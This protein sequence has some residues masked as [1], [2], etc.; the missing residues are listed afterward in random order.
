M[1]L[2]NRPTEYPHIAF[3]NLTQNRRFLQPRVRYQDA[4]ALLIDMAATIKPDGLH[5]VQCLNPATGRLRW[6]RPV[7]A[8]DFQEATR[9]GP[10]LDYVHGALLLTTDGREL[11]DFQ[12]KRLE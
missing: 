2:A 9:T 6:S 4:E 1:L 3:D 5:L 10:A 7:N 12:R 11:H 8:Y